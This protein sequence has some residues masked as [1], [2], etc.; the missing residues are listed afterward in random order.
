MSYQA[1]VNYARL[2]RDLGFLASDLPRLFKSVY[3]EEISKTA[4]Y[5]WFTSGKMRVDRLAQLLTI[6]RIETGKKLDI[7]KYIDAS[8]PTNSRGA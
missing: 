1:R 6:V 2:Q 5:A 3:G 7:W 8:R 4:A